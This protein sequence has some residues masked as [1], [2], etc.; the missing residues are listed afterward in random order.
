MAEQ[1]PLTLDD[2]VRFSWE[3]ASD[4]EFSP[5]GSRVVYTDQ[6]SL[7]LVETAGGKPC[8]LTE[9]AKPRWSPVTEEIAFLRGQPAQVWVR[10]TDD[11]E[12][13]VTDLPAGVGSFAW[14]PDSQRIAAI[15]P[16]VK[17]PVAA[18]DRPLDSIIAVRPQPLLP[19]DQLWVLDLTTAH[20]RVA[21]TA[22]PGVTWS[23]PVWSPDGGRLALLENAF[24]ATHGEEELH[25]AVVELD[26]GA[27]RYPAGRSR[28]KA[29]IPSWSPDGARLAL[30]YSPHPFVHPWHWDLGIV[31][32]SGG[33]VR[34]L[35][36]DEFID[37]VCW[38]PDGRI[39][40]CRGGRGSTRQVLRVDTATGQVQSLTAAPGHHEHLR[41]S[42][43][44]RWLVCTY[45]SP[46]TLPEVYLL[47]ADGRQRRP[48]TR[49]NARLER[50]RLAQS[51]IVRWRASDDLELEGV[52]IQ[53]LEHQQGE[54]YP[55]I[56]DL[57]GGPVVGGMAAFH[58]EYHW[59]A[60]QGF[61]VFAPD[62]RGG[63]TYGWCPPPAEAGNDYEE[64]DFLDVM[65]GVEWLVSAGYA[66][67]ARMGVHGFSY[68]A[69]L[70][71]RIISHTDR[72][73]AVVAVAGGVLPWDVNYGSFVKDSIIG[74]SILA[75][76]YGGRPWEV[77]EVYRRLNPLS[78]LHHART[79]TLILR[80]ELDGFMGA[81]VLYTWLY[82][83][84]VEVE[85]V[86][87]MGE[88]HVIRKPEHQADCW[89]RALAWFDRHLR[90]SDK[91]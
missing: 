86:R 66:D 12:R 58:P 91:R 60:A 75:Q 43:D 8:R 41:L 28:C 38:H 70:I 26:S 5:D 11:S 32:A 40:Y 50:F 16:P 90:R 55:L 78:R 23:A 22:A 85:Y 34:C 18:P 68:G 3:G 15:G 20:S 9:G 52:L 47:S 31:A 67:A 88:G 42:Q 17:A 64:C 89:R 14:S 79:P 24:A 19:G 45:Q 53:P 36:G 81:N 51:Q 62:F 74:N 77:P 37:S 46:T 87:Y 13:P 71:N 1:T 49:V 33:E 63:Q 29:Y 27:V 2:V 4:P 54:R 39:V 48:L 61:L 84:G 25:L 73:Q 82:Q 10:G 80:G 7:W 59:L 35:A 65:A 56:V 21:A 57:H 72:F 83:L 76:E 69:S 30:P 6:G 44:G